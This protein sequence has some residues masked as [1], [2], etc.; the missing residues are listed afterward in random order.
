MEAPTKTAEEAARPNRKKAAVLIK[1]EATN[2]CFILLYFSHL[3]RNKI[4]PSCATRPYNNLKFG[5]T[6]ENC[7]RVQKVTYYPSTSLVYP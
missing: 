3:L 2:I 5:G 7:P 4:R 6:A 1:I